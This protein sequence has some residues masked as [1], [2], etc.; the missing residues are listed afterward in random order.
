MRQ[1]VNGKLPAN[2]TGTPAYRASNATAPLQIEGPRT[3]VHFEEVTPEPI[4]KITWSEGDPIPEPGSPAYDSWLSQKVWQGSW[5]E[6]TDPVSF[7]SM[8]A[9]ARWDTMAGAHSTVAWTAPSSGWATSPQPSSPEP[10]YETSQNETTQDGPVSWLI[11]IVVAVALVWVW[12]GLAQ[13]MS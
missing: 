10:Q 7:S 5:D 11:L 4:K 12:V 3:Y 13:N 9:S 2:Y 8:D 1:I 6:P